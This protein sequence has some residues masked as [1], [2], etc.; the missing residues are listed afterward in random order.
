MTCQRSARYISVHRTSCSLLQQRHDHPFA[1]LLPVSE[2]VLPANAVWTGDV[3][4]AVAAARD[5]VLGCCCFGIHGLTA[6][7]E[8]SHQETGT[9]SEGRIIGIARTA[10]VAQH[11]ILSGT[12]QD[13]RRLN[14]R[15]THPR[16]SAEAPLIVSIWRRKGRAEQN[17]PLIRV[18]SM[19]VVQRRCSCAVTV[20]CKARISMACRRNTLKRHGRQENRILAD[21]MPNCPHRRYCWHTERTEN[22]CSHL[23]APQ[24]DRRSTTAL[25]SCAA[26]C[27]AGTRNYDAVMCGAAKHC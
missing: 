12:R 14:H 20:E 27:W 1:D 13:V 9:E 3:P 22:C 26:P 6:D 18:R 21:P 16:G 4:E 10:A 19:F 25:P 23:A 2:E 7:V 17:K 11:S 24:G 5:L 15:L 8:L